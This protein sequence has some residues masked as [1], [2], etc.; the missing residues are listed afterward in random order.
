MEWRR[1]EVF[2]ARGRLEALMR[3]SLR[4]CQRLAVLDAHAA[5]HTATLVRHSVRATLGTQA[6]Y[7]SY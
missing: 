6:S 7:R 5:V 2:Q 1:L 4:F 3:F